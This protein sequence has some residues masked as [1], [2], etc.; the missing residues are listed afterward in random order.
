MTKACHYSGKS[1]FNLWVIEFQWLV[2]SG[3]FFSPLFCCWCLVFLNLHTGLASTSK[4]LEK[5]ES[6][7]CI[8]WKKTCIPVLYLYFL[9][10]RF[11]VEYK[12]E[13]PLNLSVILAQPFTMDLYSAESKRFG[14]R[15]VISKKKK[16]K[17]PRLLVFL[18]SPTDFTVSALSPTNSRWHVQ[19]AEKGI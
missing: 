1:S 6:L 17:T 2:C 8:K 13:K 12:P 16:P 18:C 10:I 19:P 4:S 14:F 5:A 9:I 7:L 15:M 11:S 3:F